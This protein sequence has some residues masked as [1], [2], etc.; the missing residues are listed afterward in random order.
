[1]TNIHHWRRQIDD[2][3]YSRP[4]AAH[5]VS[6]NGRYLVSYQFVAL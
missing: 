6:N 1:M 3:G 2:L 4:L 5:G